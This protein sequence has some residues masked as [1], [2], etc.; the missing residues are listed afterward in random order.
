MSTTETAAEHPAAPP[1]RRNW[2]SV[3]SL[4]LGAAIIVTTEF[5]P[6]GFLPNVSQELGVSLG[7][8][9]LMVLVPGL[10]AAIAA[11]L[12]I[13]G[14]GRLD[15]R[16]L[17]LILGLLVFL[18]NGLAALAPD[19]A[20][21]L[22]ARIFLGVAI[23]GFWAVVPSLGFRLAGR[24]AGTR[25]TA[26]ILA[27]LSAGTVVGLPAGQFFGNLIG[28][29]STFA[30]AAALALVIVI[31]QAVVLPKI[32][33]VGRMRF[34]NLARVFRVPIGRT[35]L[36]A[37]TVATIGQFAAS[38]FVTPFL[39]Q[40][41]QLTSDYATLLLLGYGVA[42]IV[43]TLV[44]PAL[45]ERGRMVTFAAA[46]AAFGVILAV[47]PAL[48]GA[49]IVVS[50]LVVAW[51]MIWGLVPLALQTHMLTATPEAPEASSAMLITVLQLAIAI[52]SGV[53]GLLVD[54]VGLSSVFVVSGLV[55][56]AAAIFGFA[57]RKP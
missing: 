51:G 27:G 5:I 33:A 24:Q 15:R 34:A 44:G 49:P 52:G 40:N 19:F 31:V 14:A 9:G 17:I 4:A 50:I 36:I 42:G 53:G 22:V 29:R 6:V 26:I 10:S 25:A 11:P 16:V 41:V 55:A 8:A 12:V 35:I 20:I 18:S 39:L 13:V 57:A 21:V 54:S 28:W 23:G 47:L 48:A 56:I 3:F 46:S 38:T 32:P 1:S 43:G 37:G 7:T 2:L 30:A 45:V